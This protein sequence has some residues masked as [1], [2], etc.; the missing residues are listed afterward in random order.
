MCIRDR[1][2]EARQRMW[3]AIRERA[4]AGCAVLL[5]TH[6]LEEAEALADHVVVMQA[7]RTLAEGSVAQIRERWLRRRIRCHTRMDEH[8]IANWPG[9]RSVQRDGATIEI[10]AEPVEPVVARL[11]AEDPQLAALDVQRAGLADPFLDTTR[12]AEA[13]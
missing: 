2:I 9:V 6:Y 13:A 12:P 3:A 1:D 5:T 10:Q 7:G 8:G 4:A 11:L